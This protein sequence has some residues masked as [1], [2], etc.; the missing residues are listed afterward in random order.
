VDALAMILEVTL[1][2]NID[3]A[4]PLSEATGWNGSRR[5]IG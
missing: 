3:R 2:L 5:L 1:K 4:Y